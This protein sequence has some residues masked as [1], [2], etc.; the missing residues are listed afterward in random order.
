[1]IQQLFEQLNNAMS[2]SLGLALLAAFAWGVLSILLSPCHLASIPLVVG[3]VNGQGRVTTWR[4]FGL[5]SLFSFGILITIAALGLITAAAGRIAGDVGGW[6]YYAVATIFFLVGLHLLDVVPMPWS[7]P[8]NVSV[9]RKGMFAALLLGLIFGIALGPCTFAYMAPVLGMTFKVGADQPIF[10]GS[11]L[12]LY[13]VGHCSIIVAAG[14]ASGWVQRYLDWNQNNSAVT[15][16]RRI[17][18]V[19]VIFGGFW[20]IYTAP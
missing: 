19:L 4:A 17:C 5:A 12:L 18:G 15:W 10:A 8:G 6:A 13:G 9:K 11:L 3:F 20:L 16:L 1:M 2:A 7:G 14:T